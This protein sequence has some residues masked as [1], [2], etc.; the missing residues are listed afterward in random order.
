M[1]NP[2]ELNPDEINPDKINLDKILNKMIPRS[3]SPTGLFPL[4]GYY[5][6]HS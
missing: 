6:F 2:D 4:I 3:A 1:P 5:L